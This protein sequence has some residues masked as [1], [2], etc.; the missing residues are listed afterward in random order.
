MRV[1]Q[2]VALT[3]SR[4]FT[5][6]KVLVGQYCCLNCYKSILFI[7]LVKQ[8]LQLTFIFLDDASHLRKATFTSGARCQ[9]S[10]PEF[11]HRRIQTKPQIG[12]S[13]KLF[14]CGPQWPYLITG[15]RNIANCKICRVP[16]LLERLFKRCADSNNFYF[17]TYLCL[18][19]DFTRTSLMHLDCLYRQALRRSESEMNCTYISTVHCLS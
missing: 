6:C 3:Y 7:S 15:S 19:I 2:G 17:Y 13:G 18:F 5:T 14:I 1:L 11:V 16:V 4:L 8:T 9:Y 12:L 10:N